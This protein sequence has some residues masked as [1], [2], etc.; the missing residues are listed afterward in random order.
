MGQ[1]IN[2]WKSQDIG[3]RL[4]IL[5]LFLFITGI[6][7]TTSIAYNMYRNSFVDSVEQELEALGGMTAEQFSNWLGARQD[8]IRY[9]A[10]LD[11]T[12]NI[13]KATLQELLKKI[14]DSQGYYDT[15]YFVDPSGQGVVGVDGSTGNT[16]ILSP[17]KAAAFQV[18]DRAW[19][20]DAISGKDVFSEPLVSRSTGNT[21]SNVVIPVRSSGKIIGV[22]R[23][24]IQL[25]TLTERLAQIHRNEGTEIYLINKG[26]EAVTHAESVENVGGPLE[27]EAA[28]AISSGITGVGTYKNAAGTTVI[29][30]YNIIPLIGWG[31][32]VESDRGIAL[33]Q[34]SFVFWMLLGIAAVILVAVGAT[35]IIAVRKQIVLPLESAISMLNAASDQV[36]EASSEVSSSSQ[37]LAESSSEQAASLQETTSSLEEMSAQIKQTAANSSEAEGAM[38]RS[39]P[40]IQ[41]GVEAM[42]RMT[43]AMN[44]IKDSALQTSKIIKTIDDIAFQTNLLALNAAVEAARAGEAGKGFAVVAEEVRNLAQRSAE[45]AQNTSELIQKSQSSSEHGSSVAEEVSENLRKIEESINS[46]STLIV[47]ISAASKEQSVGVEQLNT[48]MG[49]MDNVVQK[50]ASTSEESASAAEE[51]SSQ[52]AEMKQIVRGLASLIGGRDQSGS[53]LSVRAPQPRKASPVINIHKNG[54]RPSNGNV[55]ANGSHKRNGVHT[56]GYSYSNGTSH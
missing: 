47:E 1:L 43:E 21:V 27:T 5:V 24:A 18:A 54:S 51:L 33:A 3:K 19:F 49:E 46:V 53:S 30:S 40:M 11:A 45:A 50:N 15:I 13:D 38:K 35:L 26:R 10:T 22:V 36:D 16:Q 8:E 2:K 23:A 20:K 17:E 29:G 48:V 28:V 56:N 31:M 41:S 25:N 44:Q 42:I 39:Q 9:I 32:A 52:A 7:L 12:R 34:V 4:T 37:E 55:R 6:S 14:S